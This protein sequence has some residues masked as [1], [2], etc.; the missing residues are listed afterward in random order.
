MFFGLFLNAYTEHTLVDS[1]EKRGTHAKMYV[2]VYV[3]IFLC[4][5]LRSKS[6]S[7]V[8]DFDFCT[9]SEA[10]LLLAKKRRKIRRK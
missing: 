7:F 8:N 10:L 3:S 2:H 5:C 4:A 6:A 9:Y 1:N